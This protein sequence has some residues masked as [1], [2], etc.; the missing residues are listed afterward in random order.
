[1]CEKYMYDS[2]LLS[3]HLIQFLAEFLIHYTR[4]HTKKQSLM[5]ATR[6]SRVSYLQT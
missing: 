4:V 1:M 3:T 2:V 5:L 6:S